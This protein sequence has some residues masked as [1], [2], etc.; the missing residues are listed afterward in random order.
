MKKTM[1]IAVM[2][3]MALLTVFTGCNNAAN[4]VYEPE[5][6]DELA[7]VL[8]LPGKTN[9]RAAYYDQSDAEWYDIQIRQN[10]NF[11]IGASGHPGETVRLEVPQEGWYTIYVY[12]YNYNGT[13]IA[14]GSQEAYISASDGE[15]II[16]I[17]INPRRKQIGF[18]I[19]IIWAPAPD[20][21]PYIE[22]YSCPLKTGKE[23]NSI[24]KDITPC[25]YIENTDGTDIVCFY[26]AEN[27]MPSGQ[28]VDTNYYLDLNNNVPVWY[29]EDNKTI[30][31]Y[32]P[33]S[34]KLAL[35]PDSSYMFEGF[36]RLQ[37]IDVSQFITESVEIMD[38]MFANCETL[39]YL[40]TG[41]FFTQNVRSMNSMFMNCK[42]ITKL[43]V[44]GFDTEKV[45]DMSYMFAGCES[46]PH[47]DISN[48]EMYQ[49]PKI[50]GMFN[51]CS[52]LEFI[53]ARPGTDWCK[54]IQE[55]DIEIFFGCIRLPNYTDEK[56]SVRYAHI[57]N[58]NDCIGYFTER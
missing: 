38:Y 27:F 21:E 55:I 6:Q 51:N 10:D 3:I 23:I 9:Q 49:N 15:L 26:T 46:L 58:Y 32:L 19:E 4:P 18:Y 31:Y 8:K 44:D 41:R 13:L 47:I 24:L 30:Y 39:T 16:T 28:P 12:A 50:Y 53:Y 1:F 7:F 42:S 35:N 48:F 36:N 57:G 54:Y 5:Q 2:A 52:N 29:D 22:D 11:C 56:T 43:P 40:D 37:S 45:L 20:D 14:E 33:E 25:E 17:T 34:K